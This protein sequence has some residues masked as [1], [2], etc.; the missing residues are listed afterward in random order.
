MDLT[1]STE[2]DDMSKMLNNFVLNNNR[3]PVDMA[4]MS[5]V[6]GFRLPALPPGAWVVFDKENRQVRYMPPGK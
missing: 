2:L 6:M 1:G 3:F 5:R 4:E